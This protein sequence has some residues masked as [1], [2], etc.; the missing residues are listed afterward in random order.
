MKK[1]IKLI[2][3][4]LF[5]LLV[6]MIP[7]SLVE[8]KPAPCL[9]RIF[10]DT[11]CWGCG[12]TRACINAIHLNIDKAL[13]YNKLVVL[14]LPICIGCYIKYLYTQIKALKEYK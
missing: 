10:L 13:E 8:A 12:I 5:P 1:Y 14:V 2:L 6:Y 4:I 3:I 11:E 9:F 7:V